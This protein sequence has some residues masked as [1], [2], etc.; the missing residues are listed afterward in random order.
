MSLTRYISFTQKSRLYSTSSKI[1]SLDFQ[2]ISRLLLITL[3]QILLVII[4]ILSVL[5]NIFCHTLFAPFPKLV[6]KSQISFNGLTE[7]L[8]HRIIY[9]KGIL[10]HGQMDKKTVIWMKEQMTGKTLWQS[11]PFFRDDENLLVKRVFIKDSLMI[12][13]NA[14]KHYA[15]NLNNGVSIWKNGESQSINDGITGDANNYYFSDL[16]KAIYSGNIHN[17]QK[18]KILNIISKSPQCIIRPPVIIKKNNERF[19]VALY[20]DYNPTTHIGQPFFLLYSLTKERILHT[21]ALLPPEVG[22]SPFGIPII[23]NNKVYFS[24]GNYVICCN[25]QDG[26]QLWKRKFQSGFLSSSISVIQNLVIINTDDDGTYAL[27]SATGENIWQNQNGGM[28]SSPFYMNSTIYFTSGGDGLLY[29]VD[30]KTGLIHWKIHAPSE[31][32]NSNDFFFGNV[33]GVNGKIYVSS[34]TTL[35][36]FSVAQ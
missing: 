34:Y 28:C 31:E 8:M 18:K 23:D 30:I 32:R 25:L 11:S 10:C 20:S 14:N 29:S 35:Y 7:G 4:V 15:I 16:Q 9:D 36:C 22:N 27:N 6:W 1:L 17:G 12:I 33:T 26:K 2:T 3:Y 19:L 21:T 5:Q 24:V 13:A